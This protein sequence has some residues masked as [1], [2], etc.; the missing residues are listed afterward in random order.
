MF[1][2]RGLGLERMKEERNRGL[3]FRAWAGGAN[4]WL[5]SYR[6]DHFF[7]TRLDIYSEMGAFSL[8]MILNAFN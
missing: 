1:G 5:F 2:M 6:S 4:A 8:C 3:M 7:T